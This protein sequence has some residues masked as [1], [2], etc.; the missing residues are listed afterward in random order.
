MLLVVIV[1]LCLGCIMHAVVYWHG[2]TAPGVPPAPHAFALP[3]GGKEMLNARS[4]QRRMAARPRPQQPGGQQRSQQGR[5]GQGQGGQGQHEGRSQGAQAQGQRQGQ[6]Q[7]RQGTG[8]QEAVRLS[9]DALTSSQGQRGAQA[10]F[11]AELDRQRA[12]QQ[13]MREAQQRAMAAAPLG[14]P[15]DSDRLPDTPVWDAAKWAAAHPGPWRKPPDD[16]AWPNTLAICAIMKNEHPDDVMQWIKYHRCGDY[17]HLR[18]SG[19]CAACSA[20]RKTY[21]V[22]LLIM[23]MTTM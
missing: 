22:G 17:K 8:Q 14:M 19:A 9:F 2:T 20:E 4:V 18:F 15:G 16:P 5:Q 12:R 10:G 21:I 6:Q 13:E 23:L 11:Q 1:G 3:S 7:H